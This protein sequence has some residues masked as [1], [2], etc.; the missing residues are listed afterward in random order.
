MHDLYMHQR[1]RELSWG[2]IAAGIRFNHIDRICLVMVDTTPRLVHV[3]T[4]LI[5][6]QQYLVQEIEQV[7]GSPS[8]IEV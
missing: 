2:L 8:R 6:V 7:L 3:Y 1:L 5:R 4:G